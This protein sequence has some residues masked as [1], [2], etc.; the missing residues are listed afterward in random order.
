[1]VAAQPATEGKDI[2][3][4]VGVFREQVQTK[5]RRCGG[6]PA[7]VIRKRE[8]LWREIFYSM[9]HWSDEEGETARGDQARAVMREPIGKEAIGSA[10]VSV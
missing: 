3:V 6:E 7:D 10:D 2:F 8:G 4:N 1:V 5:V 9:N